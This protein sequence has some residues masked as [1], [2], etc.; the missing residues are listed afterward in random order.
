[1]D[2]RLQPC[3]AGIV[4]PER[5]DDL[6]QQAPGDD[7]PEQRSE[8]RGDEPTLDDGAEREPDGAECEVHEPPVEIVPG[9]VVLRRPEDREPVPGGEGDGEEGGERAEPRERRPDPPEQQAGRDRRRTAHEWNRPPP[10]LAT[11][12]H[13]DERQR[14]RYDGGWS[15]SQG[16]HPPTGRPARQRGIVLV[17]G[18]AP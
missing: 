5:R 16:D 18:R 11:E 2:R 15:S 17:L 9:A 6:S 12:E 14:A 3:D 4:R 7:E 1:P 10:G 8:A 13:R